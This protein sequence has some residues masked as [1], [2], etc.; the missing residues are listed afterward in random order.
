MTANIIPL[1][2]PDARMWLPDD[3]PDT[4]GP[5]SGTEITQA[6]LY[7]RGAITKDHLVYICGGTQVRAGLALDAWFRRTYSGPGGGA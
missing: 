2:K 6:G 4:V 5:P 3:V 1:F 7:A